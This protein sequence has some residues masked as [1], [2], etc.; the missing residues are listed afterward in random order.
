MLSFFHKAHV[1][2]KTLKDT[3]KEW[4]VSLPRGVGLSCV[5]HLLFRLLI[6]TFLDPFSLVE[7]N[8]H[9]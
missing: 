7:K 8:L 5:L 2:L 4:N 3:D 9:L 6:H 1:S